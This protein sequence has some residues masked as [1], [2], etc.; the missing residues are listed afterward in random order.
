MKP[1]VCVVKRQVWVAGESQRCRHGATPGCGEMVLVGGE[2]LEWCVV[3]GASLIP[4]ET[5]DQPCW[6]GRGIHPDPCQFESQI[7]VGP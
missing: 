2:P 5:A 7:R 3:H 1:W 6:A 4:G